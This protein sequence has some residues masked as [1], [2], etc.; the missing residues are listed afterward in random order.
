MGWRIVTVFSRL[1]LWLAAGVSVEYTHSCY[2]MQSLFGSDYIQD[3]LLTNATPWQDILKEHVYKAHSNIV[4]RLK[5]LETLIAS[6]NSKPWWHAT[7]STNKH[8]MAT[9][10]KTQI[11]PS[12]SHW[13]SYRFLLFVQ[14]CKT[15][16]SLVPDT[17]REA[18]VG[19]KRLDRVGLVLLALQTDDFLPSVACLL[20]M[21]QRTVKLL[22]KGCDSALLEVGWSLFF[23]HYSR[24]RTHAYRCCRHRC[25][26]LTRRTAALIS[27]LTLTSTPSPPTANLFIKSYQACP[28]WRQRSVVYRQS[29]WPA[30][31]RVV[32]WAQAVEIGRNYLRLREENR[33]L[34][35]R[36]WTLSRRLMHMWVCSTRIFMRVT[37]QLPDAILFVWVERTLRG[38]LDGGCMSSVYATVCIPTGQEY[39]HAWTCCLYWSLSKH[40]YLFDERVNTHQHT[41]T[42]G[43]RCVSSYVH[44]NRWFHRLRTPIMREFMIII[45]DHFSDARNDNNND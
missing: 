11:P 20:Q 37:K 29:R 5:K 14:T 42:S 3:I 17:K 8:H 18:E 40:Y 22:L 30:A 34:V 4:R 12:I 43:G 45:A 7:P 10:S 24:D 16:L 35:E 6:V 32:S 15:T 1:C 21:V 23:E 33:A 25:C 26:W 39:M 41:V 38:A 36:R 9:A 31:G 13:I 2:D 27:D 28:V 19:C 44:F